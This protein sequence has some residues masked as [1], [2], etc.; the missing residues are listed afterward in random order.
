[1][2]EQNY[3]II[4]GQ[5]YLYNKHVSETDS[6]SDAAARLCEKYCKCL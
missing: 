4:F 6:T 5:L 3:C 1:M 2:L